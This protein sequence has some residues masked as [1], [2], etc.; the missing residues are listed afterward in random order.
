MSMDLAHPEI[1]G[2]MNITR[3]ITSDNLKGAPWITLEPFL[4]LTTCYS[5][6]QPFMSVTKSQQSI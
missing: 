5:K 6:E 1:S 2:D 3:K 4:Y